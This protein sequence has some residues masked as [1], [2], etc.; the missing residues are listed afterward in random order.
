MPK[1]P[2][3]VFWPKMGIPTTACSARS[4]WVGRWT[5]P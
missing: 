4:G 5:S 1:K 3:M 2:I